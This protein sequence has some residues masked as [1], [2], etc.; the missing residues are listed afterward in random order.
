M[1]SNLSA[2]TE[3]FLAD[4]GRTEQRMAEA[5]RQVSSGKRITVASDAPDQINSLLQLRTTRQRNTQI[6]SNLELAKTDAEVAD[7][8]LSSAIKLMD[9][10]LT[11]A[12]QASNSTQDAT[13]R[14]STAQEVETLLEQMV[15]YS[16]TTVQGRYIFSG[17]Q[18]GSPA[19]QLDLATAS[20]VQ[21]LSAAPATRQIE[22]PAGGS[23]PAALTAQQIFDSQNTDGSA[24]PDNVF[25][26]LN[27]L[28]TALL[29]NT[30]SNITSAI[31]SITQASTHLNSME[32][33]YGAVENRIQAATDFAA[34]YG[35]QLQTQIGQ[36]EDADVTTAAI[37]ATQTNTQLQ[38]AFQ[39][40]AKMPH[41]SLFDFLG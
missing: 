20:G 2:A 32:A 23:F 5:N 39:M 29:S 1:I 41:T 37:T 27:N 19:Y 31:D 26:A 24:A 22:D 13:T 40:Q 17:D 35:V 21:Q 14:Q 33:F 18:D 11:L 9:R 6:Q 12:T 10:A 15:S 3:L 28:R 16:Q 4:I 30:Q 38:A 36:K 8:A 34:N 7:S 25:A